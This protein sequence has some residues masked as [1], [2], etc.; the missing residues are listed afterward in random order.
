[1]FLHVKTAKNHKLLWDGTWIA[2]KGKKGKG[3]AQS[4]GL[5]VRY[6]WNGDRRLSGCDP[7]LVF[8]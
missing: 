4:P 5:E 6:R 8:D 3:K 2:G 7:P 1:M